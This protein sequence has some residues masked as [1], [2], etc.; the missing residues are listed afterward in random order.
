MI[1]QAATRAQQSFAQDNGSNPMEYGYAP[2]V[3]PYPQYDLSASASQVFQQ[4]YGI[5]FSGD[6]AVHVVSIKATSTDAYI[7]V[8]AAQTG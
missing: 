5:N 7:D 3:S 8:Y 2:Q 1:P 6:Q 4:F